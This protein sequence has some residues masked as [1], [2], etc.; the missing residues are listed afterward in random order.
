[1]AARPVMDSLPYA[2]PRRSPRQGRAGDQIIA[3]PPFTWMVWPV[4]QPASAL[5]R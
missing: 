2:L 5:A 1:M 3:M 4:T